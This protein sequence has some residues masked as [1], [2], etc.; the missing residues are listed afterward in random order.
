MEQKQPDVV[1]IFA[2]EERPG[3]VVFALAVC[4][5]ALVLLAQMDE[6]TKWLAGFAFFALCHFISTWTRHRKSRQYSFLPPDELANW[7]RPTEYALY[8]M[9]YV[10]LVPQ[11]GYLPT[12]LL[13]LPALVFR[14]GYRS[15]SKLMASMLVG[16]C[17]VVVFKRSSSQR[18]IPSGGW[19]CCWRFW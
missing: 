19:M 8:F 1:D 7:A 14:L 17:T 10:F 12:T 5:G 2:V 11:L 4:L 9:A 16:L 3:A 18:W 13:A 15:P 6:Q